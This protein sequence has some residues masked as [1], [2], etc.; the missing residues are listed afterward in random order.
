MTYSEDV[1]NLNPELREIAGKKPSKYRNKTTYA[2]DRTFQSGGEAVRAGELMLRLK[3]WQIFNLGFQ[4]PFPLPGKTEYRAD[5]VY[6]A[7]EDGKLVPVVEDY[8]GYPTKEYRIKK[9]LFEETYGVKIR[10]T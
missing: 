7:F 10:E 1:L 3:A 4:I 5:F 6:L 9:R 8:K 2:L